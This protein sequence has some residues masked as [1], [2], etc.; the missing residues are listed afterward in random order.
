MNG[1]LRAKGGE[2][3]RRAPR[4]LL[5]LSGVLLFRFAERQ[6]FALLFQLPPRF[7]R[8]EPDR[9]SHQILA[10]KEIL[11]H[12][13][14]ERENSYVHGFTNSVVNS[15]SLRSAFSSPYPHTGDGC[16]FRAGFF[17]H[18]LRRMSRLRPLRFEPRPSPA[19]KT[20][21]GKRDQG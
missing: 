12:P 18:G 11:S 10:V 16:P 19:R 3:S 20:A 5:R 21:K 6:F 7:T 13:P 17:T 9:P 1:A 14:T 15:A 8:S 2:L 4:L